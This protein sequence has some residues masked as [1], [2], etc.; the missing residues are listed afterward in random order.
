MDF[1]PHSRRVFMGVL[2]AS[3]LL[4][5][6][7]PQQAPGRLREGV[8]AILVDV[9]VRDRR[10]QPIRDL[11][12]DD[13]EILEDGK[14]QT[15]ES[16]TPFLLRPSQPRPDTPV[17]QDPP[18]A[19]GTTPSAAQAPAVMAIVFDSMGPQSR[20]LAVQAA[21]RYIGTKEEAANYVGL[22][23]LD[24]TLRPLVPFTRNGV[25][26]REALNVMASGASANFASGDRRTGADRGVGQGPAAMMADGG[27]GVAGNRSLAG[28][29]GELAQMEGDMI[30][31]FERMARDQQAYAQ[32][33]GL[34]AIIHTLGRLPGRKSVVLFSEGI[35]IP[36]RY[37]HMYLGVIDAANRANVS[38][39]AM[40]AAG[41]RAN[42]DQAAIRDSVN[43]AAKHGADTGYAGDAGGGAYTRNLEGIQDALRSDPH[44]SLGTLAEDTGGFLFNR[45]NNL[46]EGFDRIETD[47]ANYYVLGYTPLNTT[48]DG[49]FRKLEVRVKRPGV[50][51]AA[52]KGYFAV[53]DPGAFPVNAWEAP[54]LAAL[55]GKP[56]PNAFPIRAAALAFPERGRPGLIP[57][58]VELQTAPLTFQPAADG[59]TYSSD[60]TVLVRFLDKDNQV[61]RKVSQHYEIRG[62]AS[63]IEGARR[64]AVVF[65]R[66]SELPPGVYSM[67]T[68]VH[69]ALAGRSSV[70]LST[71]E[72]P[73]HSEGALRISSLVVVKRG[74]E[75]PE[76]ERRADNPLLVNGVALSPNLGD[77]VS[78][79]ARDVMFYFTIYPAKENQDT[80]VQIELLQN[81]TPVS[82]MP[83]TVPAADQSGRIQ[84][85]GRLPIAQM[86][87]GTYEL[88]AVVTQ[89]K[90][91]VVRSTLVR[92]A[93]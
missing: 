73:R 49:K 54:A 70:R 22:F 16:F 50:T 79:S 63:K 83:M 17:R 12:L 29:A 66:E 53:R 36:E 3:S 31:M 44:Y 88:R 7:T 21:R 69:D 10:G 59:R 34:F 11:T 76:K 41:L 15:I 32:M 86:A 25:A 30:R 4:S 74:E 42:S 75:V 87:V 37:H 85:L 52:R 72:V 65:Y 67:E 27:P 48:Y 60:F 68:V 89:G 35:A 57:V 28:P 14:R 91:Q 13:F 8:T 80:G 47:L 43:A 58:I 90:E 1:V 33:D 51:V 71:V 93:E 92:I 5:A 23:G 77:P 9:V 81:G 64:G 39:Y 84:Q 26:V 46:G 40:D 55:E 62:E 38:V 78:R 20:Q 61:A 56:I 2:V 6:Q 82:V 24:L 18:S 45:S 19:A